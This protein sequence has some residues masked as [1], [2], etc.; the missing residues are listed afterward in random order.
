[1]EEMF[2]DLHIDISIKKAQR[3][4]PTGID[5]LEKKFLDLKID[6][7]IKEVQYEI[8]P[9]LYYTEMY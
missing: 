1:L 2:V 5:L 7:S 6:I 4:A 8:Y 9:F 3:G